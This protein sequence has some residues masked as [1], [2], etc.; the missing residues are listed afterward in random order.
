M[1]DQRVFADLKQVAQR[2][3][4]ITYT[5]LFIKHGRL[6]PEGALFTDLPHHREIMSQVLGEIGQFE[7]DNGRPLITA[8][9]VL[10]GEEPPIPGQGFFELAENCG[11]YSGSKSETNKV[12]YF[13]KEL[14]KVHKFWGTKP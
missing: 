1:Y 8:A 2:R 7:H 9:C 4:M 11:L 12:V 13:A 14:S 10:A 5:D 6:F 3:S